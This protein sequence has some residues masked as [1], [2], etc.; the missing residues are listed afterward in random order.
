M[1]LNYSY[2]VLLT[3]FAL[4][5]SPAA[6]GDDYAAWKAAQSKQFT[7]YTVHYQQNYQ[8]YKQKIIQRWQEYTELSN[9]VK[10]VRYSQQL[11]V[12][13]VLDYQ[14]NQIRIEALDGKP[15]PSA[16]TLVKQLA[17]QSVDNALMSDPLVKL[18]AQ[19]HASESLWQSLTGRKDVAKIQPNDIHRRQLITYE[20]KPVEQMV[21]TLPKNS[22]FK[23]AQRYWPTVKKWSA[24]YQLDPLLV[25]SIMKTES[26]FNPMAQSPIP[27]FGLMQIV[28]SSA[29]LDVNQQLHRVDRKPTK[30]QLFRPATNIEYGSGYLHLLQSRYLAGI[31]DKQSRMYCMIAAY[32]TGAGNVAKVFHPKQ[33]RSLKLATRAI[34][35]RSAAE[36]YQQ[37]E[38]QLPYQETR[39]YIKKVTR[40]YHNYQTKVLP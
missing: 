4:C 3:L 25:L 14:H 19:R 33:Q 24:R 40:A 22:E 12:K 23:R 28:P 38:S 32:N 16:N 31:K 6:Q 35:Q 18:K 26:A 7:A 30:I 5:S 39:N 27:A 11:A 8:Q 34:N 15:L 9:Q 37:L 1:K 36:V 13:T 2:S 21:I 17:Q 29:G 10:Y 20:K